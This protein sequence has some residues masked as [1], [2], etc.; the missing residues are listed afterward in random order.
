MASAEPE[1]TARKLTRAER[2][3]VTC[4]RCEAPAAMVETSPHPWGVSFYS[5]C[6]TCWHEPGPNAPSPA[7]RTGMPAGKLPRVWDNNGRTIDRYT[8]IPPHYER[9]RVDPSLF[10]CLGMSEGGTAY[11]EHSS[12]QPGRHLGKRVP[13]EQLSLPTRRHII[14]RCY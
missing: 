10:D 9:Q 12:A 5:Y 1:R 4:C 8:V 2:K 13:W 6:A 3:R 11:S 7:V 14:H